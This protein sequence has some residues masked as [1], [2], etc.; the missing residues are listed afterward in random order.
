MLKLK[1]LGLSAMCLVMVVAC[2]STAANVL[3]VQAGPGGMSSK[4]VVINNRSLDRQ[5]EFGE[6]SIKAVDDLST[7]A[8]VMV[9][10]KKKKQVNFQYRF[11]WYDASGFELS[12]PAAWIPAVIGARGTKAL[13][14]SAPAPSAIRFSLFISPSNA[15]TDMD[16][17]N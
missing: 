1:Q 4:K 7:K 12:G 10:N 5:L 3:N 2:A 6:V 14:A 8:Q 9:R 16:S 17:K 11:I 13:Q 15:L